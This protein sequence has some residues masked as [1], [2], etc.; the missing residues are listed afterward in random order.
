MGFYKQL[1]LTFKCTLTR[2]YLF[3][4]FSAIFSTYRISP[5]FAAQVQ[6][7][8][9]RPIRFAGLDWDSNI[10]LTEVAKY[11]VETSYGCKANSVPGTSLPLLA[12]MMKKDVDV[13][14]EVWLD[15]VKEAWNKGIKEGSVVNLGVTFKGAVQGF[16]VPRYLIEGDP[17]RGIKAAAPN[18]ASVSDLPKYKELFKDREEPKKGRFYNCILGWSC[19]VINTNKLK[20]YGLDKHY[21]NFRPGTGAALSAA[22]SSAYKRGKPFVGYYWEPT[23]ILGKYD[24]VMLNEPKYN[25]KDWST[26]IDQKAKNP[27]GVAYPVKDIYLGASK[28]FYD[29]AP[30]LAKFLKAFEVTKDQINEALG[31][32]EEGGLSHKEAAIKFLKKYPS[33]W[34]S[35]LDKA[36]A[37]RV[38]EK[39]NQNS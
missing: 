11:I 33:H 22:I 24:M 25:E 30:E 5:V 13:M 18:L 35:W 6:C 28:S 7:E 39:L 23:W 8:L 16:Y 37:A 3:I 14:M 2:A 4:V 34:K 17:K 9:N 12:G 10:F 19:E 21:T 32:M 27:V 26:L 31:L 1:P 15:N 29:Q 36:G 38:E 20:A